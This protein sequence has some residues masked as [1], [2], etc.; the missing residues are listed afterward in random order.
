MTQTYPP[1]NHPPPITTHQP[2][3]V[4]WRSRLGVAIA[5]GPHGRSRRLLNGLLTFLTAEEHLYYSIYAYIYFFIQIL[6]LGCQSSPELGSWRALQIPARSQRKRATS[7][8]I[9]GP[10]SPLGSLSTWLTCR[11]VIKPVQLGYSR[12]SA[13]TGLQIVMSNFKRRVICKI[14]R[15]LTGLDK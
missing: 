14:L 13:S 5:P 10:G 12:Y 2:L 8:D 1:P 11:R 9:A 3:G 15:L 6:A 4:A 7:Y